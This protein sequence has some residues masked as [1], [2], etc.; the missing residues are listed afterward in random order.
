MPNSSTLPAAPPPQATA[1]PFCGA[2]F[3]AAGADRCPQ[4]HASATWA[5]WQQAADFASREFEQWSRRGLIRPEQWTEI[6][7]HY[8]AAHADAA[9]RAA[10]GKPAPAIIETGLPAADRCWDCGNKLEP[11]SPHCWYC[12]MRAQGPGTDELRYL[13]FL[14][15]EVE[16]L[17]Q[18]RLIWTAQSHACRAEVKGRLTALRER[19]AQERIPAHTLARMRMDRLRDMKSAGAA[20]AAPPVVVAPPPPPPPLVARM[21]IQKQIAPTPAPPPP[22]PAPALPPPALPP[23]LRPPRRSILEILLDPRSIQWLLA[24]GGVL[25]VAGLVIWLASLGL[26]KNPAIV[27]VCMG[28]GTI[29][30]LAAGCALV[31]RSRYQLAGRAITLLACLVMPLNLWFYHAHHLVGVEGHLWLAGVVCCAL[32]AAAAWVLEDVLFVYVFMGGMAMTGLLM[33]ADAHR[34]AEIA[35]PS[36]LLVVL[37][38]IGLHA[39]RAFGQGEGAFSRQRFGMAFF[40]SGQA[41][42]GAGLLLL[43]GAQ[44]IG[45]LHQPIFRAWISAPP[46]VTTD[47]VLRWVA[48]GSV[49]AATYA[50][51]YSDLVVRRVGVYV[52][53]AAITLLWGE[54]LAIDMI[55]LAAQPIVLI[56]AMSLTGLVANLL[57]AGLTPASKM[58]RPIPPLALCL[59][60][61]PVIVGVLMHLRATEVAIHEVW[62]FGLNGGY[63]IAMLLC[64]A[65]CRIGA[66]LYRHTAPSF[67]AAY[68]FG[69]AAATLVGAAGLLAIAGLATWEHQAPLLMLI[70]IGYLL[71]SRLYRGKPASEPLAWV[72]HTATAVMIASVIGSAL[73]VMPRV[74]E[75]VTG[76]RLN[77]WLALFCGEAAA[78]YALAA[79]VR[80]QGVNVYLFTIMACGAIWQL[81]NFANVSTE[82]YAL[83]FAALG[84]ALLAAYRVSLL[85]KFNQ[86]ALAQASFACANALMSLSLVASALMALSRLAVGSATSSALWL[87]VILAVTSLGA[88][89]LVRHSGWK[90]WYVTMAVAQGGLAAVL[91]ERRLHLSAW[92][93]AEVFCVAIGLALLVAGHIG[94]YREQ[95][96]TRSDIVSHNLLLG[97]LL[98]GVPLAI[99]ALAYRIGG[100]ISL[101]NEMALLTVA[102]LLLISGVLL[103]VK[104]TTITGVGLL[105]VQ[106]VMMLVF[107]GMR[108]QLAVGVYLAAGGA[109]VFGT[110]LVLS[111]YR[112]RLMELPHRIRQRQGVF[113]VLGWR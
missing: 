60:L 69:S 25:L 110:G 58:A 1:C 6:E 10:S 50:Y 94:W 75:P 63:V 108:S 85:E 102:I 39:E 81:L 113:R 98:A 9:N 68:F 14:D 93:N 23:A 41:L 43:A 19:E 72:A 66:H 56:V 15:R 31:L 11:A 52:Y 74:I 105:V 54:V 29:A 104:S 84:M 53:L 45:W 79:A 33:L 12:G 97:S 57:G 111:V 27:A 3:P 32:Y 77:L 55:H 26:F 5:D 34:I 16:R 67:A 106:L 95:Q 107:F 100:D 89:L 112:E 62:P 22:P 61:G 2:D 4:C 17:R 87:L 82:V 88:A 70:P 59:S 42:L 103:Q 38:I 40:W 36:A 47:P 13:R 73:H 83:A 76:A 44:V 86:P 7:A 8:A 48:M 71:A 51:L 30:V 46:A 101:A 109:V 78:F 80:K 21:E 49:L 35:S 99:A 24:S 37:G 64:A 65:C 90:R 91:L 28:A 20:S 96:N 18:A 92:Q